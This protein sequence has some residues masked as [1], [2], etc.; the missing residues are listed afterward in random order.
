MGYKKNSWDIIPQKELAP[1]MILIVKPVGH[2]KGQ[3]KQK[4]RSL[5]IMFL[6]TNLK[7]NLI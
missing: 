6:K 2:K 3:S 1:L 5:L 4:E 7:T